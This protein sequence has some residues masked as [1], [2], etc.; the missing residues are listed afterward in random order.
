MNR[1]IL[2]LVIFF[3]QCVWASD[4]SQ[5][6]IIKGNQDIITLNVD[7]ADEPLEYSK[8]LMGRKNLPEKYGMWFVFKRDSRNP[9]WMKNTYVSLDI[10]FVDEKKE[11]IYISK[12]TKPL[13][14]KLIISPRPYR[15]VLEVA[16]G[17]ADQLKLVPGDKVTD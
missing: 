13:S 9:F 2:V 10:I 4:V 16:A 8:G 3:S 5:V 1:L 6:K 17:L 12:N 7:V 15:Y 11:I 14:E